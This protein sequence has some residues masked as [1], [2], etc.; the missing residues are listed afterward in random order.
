MYKTLEG[1]Y[2]GILCSHQEKKKLDISND[3]NG[4]RVYYAKQNKSIKERQIPYDFTHMWNFRN[5]TDEHSRREGKI[6]LR[7]KLI[8]KQTIR[9]AEL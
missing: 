8:R 6:K 4:T 1:V 9:D 3:M 2:N 5:K 7:W